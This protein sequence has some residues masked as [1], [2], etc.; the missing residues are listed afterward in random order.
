[1][2]AR[3]EQS[4]I[5]KAQKENDCQARIIYPVKIVFKD[6][7]KIK[8]FSVKI[9]EQFFPSRPSLKGILRRVLEAIGKWFQAEA[10]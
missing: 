6:E 9:A 8:I 1:M 5:R 10:Q 2:K 4:D 3:R 7:G